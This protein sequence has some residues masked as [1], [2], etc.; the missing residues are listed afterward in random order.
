M[1]RKIVYHRNLYISDDIS[2]SKLDKIK[3]KL[4]KKPLL[5]NVYLIAF[6]SNPN[7]QLD[8]FQARQ[9][10]Q[11]YYVKYPVSVVGIASDY[12]AA[13]GLVEKIVQECLQ[14]R[15]DCALREYLG[16]MQAV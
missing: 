14:A 8:I 7:D 16:P 4:E 5:C 12:D 9:L 1:N 3:K 10:V 2:P 13:V 15:G 11:K 6:A